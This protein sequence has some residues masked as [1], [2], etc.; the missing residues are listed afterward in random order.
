MVSERSS[1]SCVTHKTRPPPLLLPCFFFLLLRLLVVLGT[2]KSD[3]AIAAGCA[4]FF[5]FFFV[6]G[7]NS[8][9]RDTHTAAVDHRLGQPSSPVASH[10][11]LS[12]S[13]CPSQ[14]SSN[15]Y[16]A[17]DASGFFSSSSSFLVE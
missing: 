4:V 1:S 8:L 17:G 10:S 2:I 16:Q 14:K 5:L 9:Y 3:E 15:S 13:C 6:H 7:W 11:Q 12:E